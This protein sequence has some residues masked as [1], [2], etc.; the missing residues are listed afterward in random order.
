MDCASKEVALAE[1]AE[2]IIKILAVLKRK[3]FKVGDKVTLNGDIAACVKPGD[4]G[5][6]HRIQGLEALV[7]WPEVNGEDID[8]W[9]IKNLES[10][11][12]SEPRSKA[13]ALYWLMANAI[14]ACT[15]PDGTLLW[16]ELVGRLCRDL[17]A[18]D[19]RFDP[20]RFTEAC[21]GPT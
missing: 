10:Y 2:M 18:Q 9:Y 15:R 19:G 4:M 20:V 17:K 13:V 16:A 12:Q 5:I 1:E 21:E 11:V 3:K 7:E 6:I 8:W 14:S